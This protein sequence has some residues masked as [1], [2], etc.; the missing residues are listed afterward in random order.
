MHLKA[1]EINGFKSFSDKIKL[2][3]KKGIT[4]IVGPNGSG[5][6]NIL[7]AILWVLGEQSHKNIRAKEGID[8]IFSGG[9]NKAP[10]S[11]GQ[12]A[13]IIDN[14]DN[15][16]PVDYNEVKIERRIYRSGENE[17]FINNNKVRLKDINELFMDTGIGKNAYSIIGQG[18]VEQII[19]SNPK[20]LRNIIEEAAGI[21][22]VKSKKEEA[23]KNLQNVEEDIEKI[24]Y[25]EN[26]ILSSLEPLSQQAE[27]TREY[28]TLKTESDFKMKRVLKKT[29]LLKESE[30]EAVEEKRKKQT[31]LIEKNEKEFIEKEEK[32]EKLN[33]EREEKE[34]EIEVIDRKIA[35]LKESS[36]K[37]GSKIGVLKER[38]SNIESEIEEKSREIDIFNSKI[39]EKN[40]RIR[41]IEEEYSRISDEN[42]RSAQGVESKKREFES[43][44]RELVFITRDIEQ[45]KKELIEKEIERVKIQNADETNRKNIKSAEAIIDKIT[46]ELLEYDTQKK[47]LEKSL[48]EFGA[49][50]EHLEKNLENAVNEKI[51]L[52]HEK[53]RVESEIRQN[54]QNIKELNYKTQN[55]STKRET[56]VK[57]EEANEG[58]FTGVKEIL[59]LK[60][61]GVIGP[62]ISIVDIPEKLESALQAAVGN[63]MQDIVV[64]ESSIAKECIE[65]LKANKFGRASFLPFDTVRPFNPSKIE[66]NGVLGI[67]SELV[68]FEPKYEKIVKFVLGNILIVEEIDSAVRVSKEGKF[69]GSIVTLEGEIISGRGKISGGE[70]VKSG[71]SVIFERKREINHL[72]SELEIYGAKLRDAAAVYEEM[73]N[74]FKEI[75]EKIVE[76]SSSE[77]S[78]RRALYD[79]NGK[80][81]IAEKE[82]KSVMNNFETIVYEKELEEDNLKSLKSKIAAG[83]GEN[84]SVSDRI[85]EIRKEIVSQEEKLQNQKRIF[86]ELNEIYSV[87]RVEA[88]KVSEQLKT[89]QDK[90]YYEKK[91]LQEY[92][93]N[94]EKNLIRVNSVKT[95]R[96]DIEEEIKKLQFE[97]DKVIKE[98]E[99]CEKSLK[100]EKESYKKLESIEK[101]SIVEI[102]GIEGKIVSEKNSF[103]KKCEELEKLKSEIENMIIRAEEAGGIDEVEPSDDHLKEKREYE[104]LER[105]ITAIGAVNPLAVEEYERVNTKY[106]FIKEQKEDLTTSK[107]SLKRLIQEI[108]REMNEKFVESYEKIRENFAYMCQEVLNSSDGDIY[109][110]NPENILETGVELM[111]KFKNKKYQ[112]LTL[113]SGGEKSMIAVAFIM[114]IFMYK[115][116]P[117]TFFDEI[118]AAL[119]EANTKKL[120]KMLKNFTEM[121]Q[122]ILI[123]HNKETMKESDVLYGVTMNKEIGSSRIIS[124]EI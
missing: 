99:E 109:L 3:F 85:E 30:K 73:Q 22:K 7:D 67:A 90:I 119:D 80:K 44:E 40:S 118:E 98:C 49:E 62:F 32:L 36:S 104:E 88:A 37:T 43:A 58:F 26:E 11:M 21:K 18:K 47:E 103:T 63:S 51:T 120:I 117:F 39:A 79:I 5:K 25:I 12:V 55:M 86:E 52:N 1:I 116:S 48:K 15:F 112:S 94:R 50:S 89:Y 81:G 66:G 4:S 9:K 102:R 82:Y 59:K 100:I 106:L 68:N 31:I 70:R 93:E 107:D 46:K 71:I 56:L 121:S 60:K 65:F 95:G 54:E 29:L 69:S 8:V 124:V 92:S 91:E 23:E 111:V 108:E 2:D 74:K 14:S 57:L 72:E 45:L 114:A 10:K 27:K 34:I 61:K 41:E 35:Q 122:F 33:E 110:T 38:V 42:S 84:S 28:L 123:T 76:L 78:S 24:G 96:A 6:S 20:D 105:K 115:P 87:G 97:M 75:V 53:V 17:Y 101:E 13:L 64:E 77:E 16:L 19:L 83:S 113:L